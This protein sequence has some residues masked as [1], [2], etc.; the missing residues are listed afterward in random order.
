MWLEFTLVWG[1]NSSVSFF[2][3]WS[4]STNIC[5]SRGYEGSLQDFSVAS[6]N[7][8]NSRERNRKKFSYETL[9][10]ILQIGCLTWHVKENFT[11]CVWA[12]LCVCMCILAQ[13]KY[14]LHV[15]CE[16]L[17]SYVGILSIRNLLCCVKT[18]I[19]HIEYT[20]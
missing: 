16:Q 10:D 14:H 18:N 2:H 8:I 6:R 3:G 17:A 20:K 5:P 19:L 9:M 4:Y 7:A 13:M 1:P 11:A 15:K 12:C